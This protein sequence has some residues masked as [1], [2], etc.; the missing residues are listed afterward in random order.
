MVFLSQSSTTANHRILNCSRKLDLI[1]NFSFNFICYLSSGVRERILT[2]C[3][4]RNSISLKKSWNLNKKHTRSSI[5]FLHNLDHHF[6]L[7]KHHRLRNSSKYC[8]ETTQLCISIYIYIYIDS[9]NHR[10]IISTSVWCRLL[11]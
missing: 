10:S 1:E 3:S 5:L 2:F 8:H 11:A 7:I 4:M 6:C 9:G